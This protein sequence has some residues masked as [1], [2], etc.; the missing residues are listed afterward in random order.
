MKDKNNKNTKKVLFTLAVYDH[1]GIKEYLERQAM[2]GWMLEKLTEIFMIF[3][4]IE[5]KKLQFTVSY[6]AKASVFDPKPTQEQLR[7]QEFCEH[8][9]WKHIASKG[10]LQVFCNEDEAAIPIETDPRI[11][12]ESIHKTMK[13]LFLPYYIYMYEYK[14]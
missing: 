5:P 9:G 11:E 7:F 4:R 14:K 1:T 2:E 13:K 10:E 6:F 12:V 3:R 8:T